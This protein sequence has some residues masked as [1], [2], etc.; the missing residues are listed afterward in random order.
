MK[1]SKSSWAKLP[2]ILKGYPGITRATADVAV[3]VIHYCQSEPTA[4]ATEHIATI[5]D[6]GGATVRRAV[7]ALEAA[8]LITVQRRPGLPSLYALTD[9]CR[10]LCASALKPA[11]EQR[12]TQH[13]SRR[14]KRQ[15]TQAELDDLNEYLELSNN[16]DSIEEEE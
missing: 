1:L 10:E 13:Q 5:V 16:F 11:T 4:I 6:C 9:H 14:A 12:T 7:Y 3:V 8:D 15:L 2:L